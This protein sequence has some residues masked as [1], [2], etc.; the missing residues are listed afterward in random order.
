MLSGRLYVK[1]NMLDLNELLGI[2]PSSDEPQTTDKPMEAVAVPSNLNLSLGTDLQ[3]VLFHKM[4]ISAISGEMRMAN[5]AVSLDRLSLQ[6]FDGKGTASGNY[7]TVNPKQPAMKITLGLSGASFV[8]T[9]NEL[10]MVQKMVPIFEKTGGDYSLALDMTAKLDAQMQPD[11]NSVNAT[12]EIKSAN[13]N[14]KNLEAFDMI[15]KALNNN[16]LNKIEAKDVDIRFT[17]K[18]GRLSTQP[19]DLKL[20]NVKLN[21]SGSTG[22]DQTIDYTAKVS[23]PA[24]TTG[25]ILQ[26]V[27]VGIGGTFSSP[28]ISVGLKEAAQ[29]AVKNVVDQQIQKLTSSESLG[30]EIQKQADNLR[31]QAKDAGE[32]LV[33]AAQAQS[34]KLVEEAAKNGAWAKIAAQAAGKKLVSEAQK[35][36]DKLT[37]DAEAQ[38]T[39]L[40]DK[41]KEKL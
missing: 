10:E 12:G 2:I 1:S 18:N 16:Q 35:Q 17:I 21:L 15:A 40:Q 11:L 36:A 31:A 33:A 20:G 9:F 37:S 13:I 34:D 27:N 23:L 41:T 7:S 8:R 3:Q 22:L 32:K 39:K 38:I 4:T 30:D 24:G 29:E 26:N 19:F 6:L 25:G 5:Q 14:I 28:K